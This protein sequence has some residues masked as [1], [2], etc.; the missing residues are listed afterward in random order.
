MKPQILPED[1]RAYTRKIS[2]ELIAWRRYFHRH[3]EL[4]FEER[5]TQ[6]YIRNILNDHQIE[7]IRTISGTGLLAEIPGGGHH[8]PVIILRADMDALPVF[9]KTGAAYASENKGVMHACG[10]DAHMT[11]LLGAM[12]ILRRFPAE[13]GRIFLLFQPAEEKL[14]G[15]AKKIVEEGFVRKLNPDLVI[16]QHVEPTMD[17]G[18][19]GYREGE[20]M[21]SS[22]EV[23]ITVKG[24]GGHAA[25]PRSV[26][27]TTLAAAETIYNIHQQ[28]SRQKPEGLP[29]LISFGKIRADGATNV[30]PAE[31]YI[32]GTF[33]SFSESW[34]EEAHQ[35][36][37]GVARNTCNNYKCTADIEIVK[38]YPVLVNEPQF[39]RMA[40]SFSETFLGPENVHSLDLRMTSEDFAWYSRYFPSVFFRLGV[41]PPGENPI[42]R[43]HA[44]D[45]DIDENALAAGAGHLAWLALRFSNM[46]DSD[47]T[48]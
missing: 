1:I 34:R 11:C 8:G 17:T 45:F 20:Y 36:I 47:R 39:T 4:S 48:I 27:Q 16:G 43:L 31:V 12:K 9:E 33:R 24:L 44:P 40:R 42:R 23:Y 32:E 2:A 14:P 29:T 3:P 25:L 35:I 13:R 7:N 41:K 10:H 18:H 19:V 21:A 26:S 15:G 38:G 5:E 22:D 46:T 37:E 28:I 30:I 6:K